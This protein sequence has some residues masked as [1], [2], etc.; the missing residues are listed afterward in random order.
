M[1][2]KRLV[3]GIRRLARELCA[4]NAANVTTTFALATIPIVGFVGSAVDY[5]HANSV[6]TAMQAAVDSTALMLSK[7][8]ASFTE[9]QL[10]TKGAEYFNA[11]FN[12]P[13]ATGVVVTV[14]YTTSGGAQL[15]LN[16]SANVKTSFMSIMGHSLLNVTA[17]SQVK[18]G[19]SRLRVALALDNTGS[20]A[21]DGK[22]TALK[23]ATKGL[24]TQLK[25]AAVKNGDVYVSIVPFNKDVNVG[26][27]TYTQNWI[28]WS[29][30][31]DTF[32]ERNGN[33][34]GYSS[35]SKPK[36][37]SSCLSNDG[38]WTP[39]DHN[40]WN[41]CVMD[42]DQDFDTTNTA[43]ITSN[44]AT[45]FPAEQFS[46]CPTQLLALTYDW[47]ALNDKVDDMVSQGNT[48]QTIGLQ[49]AFQSL[50]SGPFVIPPKD[51][52]Y[53]YSEVIILMTDGLNTQNRFSSSQWSIDARMTLACNNAKSAGITIYAVQVNTG[54]DPTQTVLKNCASD[55]GKFFELTQAN[56][57]VST[58]NSIGTALS[59][60][61][62]AE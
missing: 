54:G 55:P 48:N 61:R 26:A 56:Q 20:M 2:R 41:G 43:P 12:R 18:W 1:A 30:Q 16:A 50:T 17:E 37:K 40:T 39:A 58:F 45:Q 57:L 15:K 14:T 62:I 6:R 51:P 7:D 53:K 42:R 47:I 46:S 8:A 34:T 31:S 4:A 23:T 38:T 49:W 44:P 28:K 24:L 11:L 59:N 21:W 22:M 10:Q 19:N 60:L 32:E 27:S 3:S 13:E 52:N 25:N 5:S 33:C 36:T 9:S 35:W 29:G